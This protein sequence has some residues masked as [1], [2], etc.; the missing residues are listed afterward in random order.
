MINPICSTDQ[1]F[2]DFI[3]VYMLIGMNEYLHS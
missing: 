2:Y 3:M 1:K